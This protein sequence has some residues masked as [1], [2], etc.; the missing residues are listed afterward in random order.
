MSEEM[1]LPRRAQS[2]VFCVYRSSRVAAKRVNPLLDAGLTH[3]QDVRLEDVEFLVRPICHHQPSRCSMAKTCPSCGYNSIGPF[4]DNCPMCAEPVR[5]VRSDT[6][7][8]PRL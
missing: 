1:T 8:F 3:G 4:T 5:N 6:G 7:G 2:C